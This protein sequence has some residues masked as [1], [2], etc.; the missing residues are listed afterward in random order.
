MNIRVSKKKGGEE[1][2]GDCKELVPIMSWYAFPK[3]NN[4]TPHVIQKPYP[5]IRSSLSLLGLINNNPQY[6]KQD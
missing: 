3:Y 6:Q 2:M 4:L 5:L 1:W